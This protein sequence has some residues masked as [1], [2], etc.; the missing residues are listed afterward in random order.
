[1]NIKIKRNIIR[2]KYCGDVIESK[3]KYDFKKCKCGKVGIDDGLE[4]CKRIFPSN[5][6]DEHFD[7]LTEYE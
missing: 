5:P 7:D 4:Y 1:M 3:D 2:C 6:P